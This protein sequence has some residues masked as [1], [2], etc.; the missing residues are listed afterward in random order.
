MAPLRVVWLMRVP[1]SLTPA[2]C[3]EVMV[4]RPLSMMT[5]ETTLCSSMTQLA[6]GSTTMTANSPELGSCLVSAPAAMVLAAA[7]SSSVPPLVTKTSP[8]SLW[9]RFCAT[10]SRS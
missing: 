1:S 8:G 2:D 6:E 3:A 5:F 4:A 9:I 7:A 10:I